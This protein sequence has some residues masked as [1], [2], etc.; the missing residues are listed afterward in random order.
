MTTELLNPNA[1][2]SPSFWSMITSEAQNAAD[3]LAILYPK[4][5]QQA[6][7]QDESI[8]CLN[9]LF[10]DSHVRIRALGLGGF[11]PTK[12]YYP[13]ILKDVSALWWVD[14]FTAGCNVK[15]TLTWFSSQKINKNGTTQYPGASAH[16][17]IGYAEM[18]F[19]I[20]PITCGGWH[21]PRRNRDSIAVEMVN[22]GAV[23]KKDDDYYYNNGTIKIPSDLVKALP[24]VSLNPP[25]RGAQRMQ[26]FTTS[27]ILH[28]LTLK[29]LVIAALP[30]K[31]DIHRMSAH[32]DWREGKQDT[33]PLF[34]FRDVN[35][36]AFEF[37]PIREYSFI[38][39]YMSSMLE[40][41]KHEALYSYDENNVDNPEYGFN[42][43]TTDKDP[44]TET[45]LPSMEEMFKTLT[46]MGYP[47]KSTTF[48]AAAKEQVFRF[49]QNWNKSHDNQLKEDGIPGPKTYAAIVQASSSP[50]SLLT[51]SNNLRS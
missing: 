46:A 50:A 51:L 2:K 49:Q 13:D 18:P 40:V 35:L 8:R 9:A 47:L 7:M 23:Q 12:Q 10:I 19:Y 41:A 15:G 4:A 22:V 39:N 32:T 34:P 33:G 17:V 31:M 21:E 28:N 43:P 45:P 38:Q 36:S 16:F 24:P 42:T 27:Q 25:F 44:D 11:Y 1:M 48:D 20:I 30:G 26:P 14:H 6:L 5:Q 37:L 3:T 29:R